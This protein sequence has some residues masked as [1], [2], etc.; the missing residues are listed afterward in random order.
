MTVA[1]PFVAPVLRLTAPLV[2]P[3]GP[4]PCG[5]W[6]ISVSE[7]GFPTPRNRGPRPAHM[8]DLRI[9]RRPLFRSLLARESSRPGAA[10]DLARS[11][12]DSLVSQLHFL[13]TRIR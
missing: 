1:E 4:E 11:N 13:D 9:H 7:S 6:D 5:G 10:K 3:R 2:T 12:A 8:S